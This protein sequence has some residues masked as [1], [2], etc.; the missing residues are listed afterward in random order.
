M[1]VPDTTSG[2]LTTG[3]SG[4]GD[5]NPCPVLYT[6]FGQH[7]DPVRQAGWCTPETWGRRLTSG[8]MARIVRYTTAMHSFHA[9][10]GKPN[11]S[12]WGSFALHWTVLLAI[13][14]ALLLPLGAFASRIYYEPVR[15]RDVVEKA[16]V[17][18]EAR[19]GDPVF[20]TRQLPVLPE[21]PTRCGSLDVLVYDV[22]VVGIL[23]QPSPMVEK[24][25]GI[26]AG[27]T[28]ARLS[29][30]RRYCEENVRKSPLWPQYG[31]GERSLAPGDQVL[32]FLEQ[33]AFGFQLV[34]KDAWENTSET[35]TVL[36]LLKDQ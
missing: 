4:E 20:E 22:R 25:M 26:F 16:D 21:D 24:R 15:L 23:K 30:E 34:A 11:T 28:A 12:E 7:V 35:E 32:M 9:T 17:V 1:L 5:S 6:G 18:I 10:S 8:G 2:S 3:S 14:L 29:L 19:L 36:G 31:E 33:K 13:F 27:N